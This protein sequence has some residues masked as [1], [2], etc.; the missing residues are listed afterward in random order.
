MSIVQ[1]HVIYLNVKAKFIMEEQ[2]VTW[3]R[4]VHGEDVFVIRSVDRYYPVNN[5]AGISIQDIATLMKALN[6]KSFSTYEEAF[7]AALVEGLKAIK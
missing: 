2:F 4:D 7:E 5:G 1:Q 6:W 3:L